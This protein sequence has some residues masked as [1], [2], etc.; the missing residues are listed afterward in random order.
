MHDGP[1]KP[2]LDDSFRCW[3]YITVITDPTEACTC[4][5]CRCSFQTPLR[6]CLGPGTC[7]VNSCLASSLSRANPES[8]EHTELDASSTNRL[9]VCCGSRFSSK[10]GDLDLSLTALNTCRHKGGP[11]SSIQRPSKTAPQAWLASLAG[12]I[13]VFRKPSP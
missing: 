6:S 2:P 11:Y 5:R 4:G 13:A 12:D 7:V 3:A 9:L 1:A 8:C 10:P